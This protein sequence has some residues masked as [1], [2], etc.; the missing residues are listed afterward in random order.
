MDAYLK[1]NLNDSGKYPTEYFT[2]VIQNLSKL[3]S[4]KDFIFNN[5]NKNLAWRVEIEISYK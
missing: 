3:D 1:L 4:Y 2:N 5:I